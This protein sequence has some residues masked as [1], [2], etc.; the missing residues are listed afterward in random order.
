MCLFLTVMQ[1][2]VGRPFQGVTVKLSEGD[3]GEILV[4]S[5]TMFIG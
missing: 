1:G 4:K 2:Y 3:H 5:P